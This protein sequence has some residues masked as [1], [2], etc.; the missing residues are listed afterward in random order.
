MPA[1][2]LVRKDFSRA[3][4]AAAYGK[5]TPISKHGRVVAGIAPIELIRMAE[6]MEDRGLIRMA[7]KSEKLSRGKPR[8]YVSDARTLR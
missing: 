6:E 3:V 4:D 7:M 2:A 8:F 5:I 1:L